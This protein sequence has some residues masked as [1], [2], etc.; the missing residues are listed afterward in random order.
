MPSG[1]AGQP[2][3]SHPAR[4]GRFFAR[5]ALGGKLARIGIAVLLTAVAGYVDAIGWISL[6][7]VF[8]AQMSGNFL[9]LAVHLASGDKPHVV[10]QSD[11]I[12]AFFA[13]LVVSGSIIEIGMRQRARRIFAA[14]LAIELALLAAFTIAGSLALHAGQQ[15][16]DH[17]DWTIGAL[18]AVVALA[19]GTQNT[20]L[21]MAGVLS[22]FTTHVTGTLTGFSEEIIVCA[23]AAARRPR[24]GAYGGLKTP[25]LR[26]RHPTAFRNIGR[27]AALLLGFFLGALAGATMLT[28]VGLGAAMAAPLAVLLAIA[29]LDWTHPLTQFP[30]P[31][32]QE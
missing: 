17:P 26:E 4:A 25:V 14:A 16:G 20:S 13:G 12:L 9:L 8:T 31:V 21:R 29:V 23:F 19:M 11:V 28:A 30:S 24:G 6:G 27:S 18:A 5:N 22:Q 7:H 3:G 10:L 1:G 15:A 2:S 32:E